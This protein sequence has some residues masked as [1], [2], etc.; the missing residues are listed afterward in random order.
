MSMQMGFG[1]SARRW[2][3]VMMLGA[4]LPLMSGCYGNFPL[5]KAVYKLNGEIGDDSQTGKLLRTVVM[6]VFVIVPVYSFATLG[7]AVVLNLIEF[8]TGEQLTLSS[9]TETEDGS[10]VALVPSADGQDLT[11]TVSRDGK[12]VMCE[13]FVRVSD[14][15]FEVRGA[16]GRLNGLVKT[17]ADGSITL[18]HADGADYTTLSRAD[19]AKATM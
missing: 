16:D 2:I 8:W 5:T 6:W 11:M 13:K 12:E 7:D 9:V 19:I 4:L 18:S 10:Q 3:A 17:N 14:G 1:K 15:T